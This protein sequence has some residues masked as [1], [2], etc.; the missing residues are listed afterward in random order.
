MTT[1]MFCILTLHLLPPRVPTTAVEMDAPDIFPEI[2]SIWIS[3]LPLYEPMD[4]L[5]AIP[6]YISISQFSIRSSQSLSIQP[7][8]TPS[9]PRW[10]ISNLPCLIYMLPPSPEPIP[11]PLIPVAVMDRVPSW[12]KYKSPC[13]EPEYLRSSVHYPQSELF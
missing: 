9:W 6:L 10:S 8:T 11:I 2:F 13:L 1:L 3:A 5:L 12:L 7:I 4:T